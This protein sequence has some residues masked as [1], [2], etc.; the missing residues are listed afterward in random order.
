MSWQKAAN[1]EFV[2]IIVNQNVGK[3]NANVV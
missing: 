2:D 1:V 3:K